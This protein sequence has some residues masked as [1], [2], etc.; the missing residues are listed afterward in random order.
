MSNTL[1]RLADEVRRLTPPEVAELRAWIMDYRPVNG[2]DATS[3]RVDWSGHAAR[4]Q[5]IFGDDAP[6]RENAVLALREEERF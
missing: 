2:T 4:V 5:E 6:P 1:E 3:R